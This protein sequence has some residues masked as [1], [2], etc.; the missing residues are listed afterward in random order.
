VGKK[1]EKE[2]KSNAA[3]DRLCG[4][5][6]ERGSP[7]IKGDAKMYGI[8]MRDS[9]C[10]VEREW[11]GLVSDSK[12]RRVGA[13]ETSEESRTRRGIKRHTK[14]EQ[15][16]PKPDRPESNK[17]QTRARAKEAMSGLTCIALVEVVRSCGVCQRTRRCVDIGSGLR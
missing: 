16:Y 9:G 7:V 13:S 15:I 1:K 12:R 5:V 11:Q 8:S 14:T 2:L 6:C 17:A 3:G 10:R 4:I